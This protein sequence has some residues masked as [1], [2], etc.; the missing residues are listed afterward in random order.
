MTLSLLDE[1]PPEDPR[2]DSALPAPAGWPAPPAPAAYHELLG[3]IVTRIAPHTE[4]DPVAILTQLLVAFGAAVGRGAYF[5]VEATRHHPNEFMLLVGDSS[6]A[7]KGSSWD[8]VRRLITKADPTIAQRTL[9]G[10]SSGEGLIW[11]VRDPTS[12]D[13]G[14]PDQRLLVIEPEFA[15]VLRASA[16]ELST[17]SPTL[18]CAWD[19]RPLAILTRTAPAR[20]SGAHIALIGH[21]TREE[22]RRHTTH[23]ELS[24]GYLNRILIVACRRQRLLPE[25][26]DHDPLNATGLP[27]LLTATLKHAHTAGQIRL[28]PDARQL[29][30]DAYHQLARPHPGALGQITARAEAHTIRLALLY[31]LADGKHQIGPPHLNAAVALHDY[32]TRSAAWALHGA[33]GQP[34][35]EQIDAAL[36]ANAAGLTRSQ[37]S[38][39]LKHNQPAGQIDHALR[40]LQTANRATVTQIATGGRPAQLWTATPAP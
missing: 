24:N 8:H 1:P 15:S 27:R 25:G 3:E 13:P 26:G 37:I 7:R 5:T 35:A 10:L 21:I 9:T 18:R 38:D 33:T 28:D 32:A 22:L 4:A 2:P 19:G 36:K 14:V 16:R 23:I 40:A 30:H 20:A 31:A 11:A 12:H 6:K 29:W 39:T 17:L 34:L